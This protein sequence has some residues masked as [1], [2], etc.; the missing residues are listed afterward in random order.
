MGNNSHH[1]SN[2]SQDHKHIHNHSHNLNNIGNNKILYK[3]Y[4]L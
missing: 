3:K 2:K 1:F 4:V